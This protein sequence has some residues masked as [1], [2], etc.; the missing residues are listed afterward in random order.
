MTTSFFATLNFALQITAPIFI[1]V[2]LGMA[3]KRLRLINDG[4][5]TS[6]SW[7]VFSV[8]LP[9]LLF[10]N[11]VQTDFHA[12]VNLRL[13]VVGIV[14]TLLAFA[15]L[16]L[17]AVVFIGERAERGIFVQGS[18]R[19]NMGV[20]G[21]AFCINAYGNAG[22]ATA[23]LY[24]AVLTVLYNVL[25]V[26]VLTQTLT[27]G[28]EGMLKRVV[29]NV[30]KNPI[31]VSIVLAAGFSY[32]S[33]G[34]PAIL[35]H[36]GEYIS[37]MTLPLALLCIG[38]SINLRELRLSSHIPVLSVLNKLVLIPAA[39]VAI[40]WP[41]GFSTME[42]GVLFLM[43]SAPTATASYIMVHAMGG[44]GTMAANIVVLS[45][46]LSVVS[47]SAGIVVLKGLN[48]I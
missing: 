14:A 27:T 41:L 38:G 42:M 2:V 32:F 26:Y 33:L 28:G 35:M 29:T 16:Y 34:V 6:A 20:I 23:S 47:V 25:S 21:L 48:V 4:F 11:I 22:L 37:A 39:T 40:A 36:A 17:A 45:T 10:V 46:L 43:A 8:G 18:F 24:M 31:V 15:A 3:F 7:L 5:I 9:T 30:G 1:L 12:V 13:L 44:K 19:G